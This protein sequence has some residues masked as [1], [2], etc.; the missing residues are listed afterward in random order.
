M[1]NSKHI[2]KRRFLGFEGE[3]EQK[4][5]DEL[6]THRS[7]TAIENYFSKNGLYKVISIGSYGL[8]GNYIDQ[9]IRAISND[10]TDNQ[11]VKKNELTMVLND[12]T[13]NGTII[14][15][16]LLIDSS[17]EFVVNQRTEIITPK[18]VFNP[19]F[20]FALLNGKFRDK[21]KKIVQGGTQIYVNYSSVKE[22][23][24][25]IPNLIEQQQLGILFQTIDRLITLHQ[26]KLDKLKNL[27][28]SYHAELFPAE[29]ERV[30][31]RRF[32]GFEGEWEEKKL[33]EVVEKFDNLRIPV[34]SKDRIAGN[35]PYYGAN[36][37]QDYVEGFTH[38]GEF[39]LLAED[40]ANDL[41]DYPVRYVN[42]KVWVN[43]HAHVI[44]GKN[45]LIDNKFL[46]FAI[47]QIQMEPYLVGG[48]RA[49][50]NAEIMMSLP[51]TAPEISEQ[52]MIGAFLMKVEKQI[53]L[54]QQKLN[55]LKDLKKAYLNELF[56]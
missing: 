39:V 7:G 9:G 11:V 34:A 20:A 55:K 1:T 12:K 48:G 30:P 2:P 35:I 13:S 50:L 31:K 49:K 16:T 5:L 24:L 28:K 27:K 17:D 10:I 18:N 6:S 3:W 8:D 32:P 4:Q 22:L 23:Q 52:R 44:Q 43:N 37:I 56:V 54:Q 46:L 15:R 47:K 51:L 53:S 41:N 29:G 45:N 25:H 40:G 42:G 19:L 14:G 36:G 21:V 26:H 38:D 33:G